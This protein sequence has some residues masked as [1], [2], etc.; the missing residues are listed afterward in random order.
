MSTDAAQRDLTYGRAPSLH[1]ALAARPP[2]EV[3]IT[4]ALVCVAYFLGTQLGFALTFKPHPISTLW[5]PNSILL[6]ALVLTAPRFW[7]IVLL[8]A[9]PAHL[10]A[11]LHGG[12]PII[13]V[14]AWFVSNCSEALIGAGCIRWAVNGGLRFDSFRHVSVFVLCGALLAPFLSSFIDVT[15]VTLIGWG[16]GSYWP[17]WR[18]RFFS[19]VLASIALVPVIVTW[20]TQGHTVIRHAPL[21]RY[22]EAGIVMLGLLIAALTVFGQRDFASGAA[23]VLLYAP[24]PFLLWAAVRLGPLGTSTS[25]LVI[26]L[27]A[28]WGAIHGRGPFVATSPMESALAVQFFLIV[29]SIPLLFLAAVIE[30]SRRTARALHESEER[31]RL[32]MSAARVGAWEWNIRRDDALWSDDTRLIFGFSDTE[33]T[34]GLDGFLERVHPEDR[35]RVAR[36]I[37]CAVEEGASYEIEFRIVRPDENVRWMF[38]KGEVLYDK[39]GRPER[40]LGVNVDITDR[41]HVEDAVRNEATLR[42]SETRFRQMADA[43]PQIVWGAR[44]DGYVDYYNRRAY[45]LTGVK[46]CEAGDAWLRI[47]HPDDQGRCGAVWNAAVRAGQP[48]EAECRLLMATGNYR[49]YLERA[50]P[51]RDGAGNIIRWYGTSTDIDDQKRAE[52]ALQE[53]RERLEERVSARTLEL[54]ESNA[55][56]RASREQ[57]AKAFR[58][59][60]SAMAITRG[61]DGQIIDVNDRWQE[62]F[63]YSRAEAIGRTSIQLG[64]FAPQIRE[65]LVDRIQTEGYVRDVPLTLGTR[66][67]EPRDVV[68]SAEAAEMNAEPCHISL[69]RDVTEQRRL[70]REAQEQR[71]QMT[72]LM[73]VVVLGQLSGALA[74]ELN[75]PLTAILSNAQAGQRFLMRESIDLDVLREIL[76]DI[77]DDDKRAGEVIRRLRALLRRGEMQLEPLDINE[78]VTEVLDL[79]RSDLVARRISVATRLAPVLPAVRADRV[80]LQ[81]VL[82]NL[83]VNASEAMSGNAFEARKLTI[84]SVTDTAGGVEISVADHGPGIPSD[85]L[86]KLFEPF[87]TTKDNGLGLGLSISRSIVAAHAGR[88]WAESGAHGGAT[89]RMVL[90]AF[91]PGAD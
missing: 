9:F 16:E 72:H 53:M 61:A 27:A 60:P 23:P 4:A 76:K 56:L 48:Y 64:I 32:A 40:M 65:D 30:E 13:Q 84:A 81:Q 55:A 36:A 50:L 20:I 14:V 24:V 46:N 7:W 70:E 2:R 42:A 15:F 17:L 66:S 34:G 90:P 45:E 52:Q 6:A 91:E 51:L 22:A 25:L 33:G 85:R 88:L 10:A 47:V 54:S 67:G 38:G 21:R 73:R 87:F 75:Q 29:L 74:H 68:F 18:M 59:S 31:F 80:Q 77:V 49:W 69:I 37:E 39:A 11:Q 57:F 79:A 71:R 1:A 43:M 5:P 44:P 82:L 83:I 86:D 63:G 62:L 78:V 26:T 58:S 12:V 28:I 19:N 8:A 35:K 3:W 41:K 89:L